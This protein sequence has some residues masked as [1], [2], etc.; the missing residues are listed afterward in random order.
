MFYKHLILVFLFSHAFSIHAHNN[1]KQSSKQE[2]SLSHRIGLMSNFIKATLKQS[3]ST[4]MNIDQKM[5]LVCI[6]LSQQA[7]DKGDLPFGSVITKNGKII[8]QASNDRNNKTNYHAEILALNR[9]A[10][11]LGTADLSG[12]TLYTNC[13]PCPMCSF[14][15]REHKIQKVVFALPS[16]FM[17]GYSKWDI[18]ADTELSHFPP[19]FAS[20]PEVV[21]PVLEKEAKAVFDKTPLWMF[22]THAR[23]DKRFKGD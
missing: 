16:P 5:I 12:C 19:F 9:A 18:L 20:P 6:D 8:A 1:A 21:G 17:G 14:M 10:D 3:D 11:S 15:I 2:P 23:D 7:V 4:D 13:E 22:G